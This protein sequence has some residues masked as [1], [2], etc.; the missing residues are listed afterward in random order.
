MINYTSQVSFPYS[1]N[2]TFILPFEFNFDKDYQRAWMTRN[3]SVSLYLSLFYVIFCFAVQHSMQHRQPFQVRNVLFVWNLFLSFFSLIGAFRTLPEL[4]HVL[5]N[6]GVHFSVCDR[7]YIEY[8]KIAGFWAWIFTL[9]KS[10]EL[11]DT[12]FIVLRKQK[13]IFLHWSHHVSALVTSWYI[14]SDHPAMGRWMMTTNYSVHAIM[15]AYYAGRAAKIEIPRF[16]AVV[17][18]SLQIFQMIICFAASL[19]T[20]AMKICGYECG[21]SWHSAMTVFFVYGTFFALFVRLFALNYLC[22]KNESTT[23]KL[24]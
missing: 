2:Y 10:L 1:P 21:I 14:Y 19:Y 11:L 12:V 24:N 15:Y 8:D 3:W 20:F 13:L 4:S 16:F 23:K 5:W 9:S 18:T 6:Y 22:N 7:S 17:I